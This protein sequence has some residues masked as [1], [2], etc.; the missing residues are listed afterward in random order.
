MEQTTE[1][2]LTKAYEEIKRLKTQAKNRD[3]ELYESKMELFK[4][5]AE[6]ANTK[7]EL[8]KKDSELS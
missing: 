3:V 2:D 1:N 6:L 4:R 5:D 7:M 8:L